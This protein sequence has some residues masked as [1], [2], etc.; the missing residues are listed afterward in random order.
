[1]ARAESK[2]GASSA[3]P[4]DDVGPRRLARECALQML[5]GFDLEAPSD[6]AARERAMQDFW[7]HLDGP[8]VGREYADALVHGVVEHRDALDAAIRAANAT[9]R[10]E[11]MSRVDRTLLRIGAYEML[12]A[13]VP[14]SV[15]IDEAVDM[16]RRFGSDESTAF[17]NGV[18]DR[19]AR[20]HSKL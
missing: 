14:G 1:V 18:L 13:N 15:A 7:T 5:Y 11:R 17:V 4:R 10:L 9:W 16:A 2:P 19:I 6:R 3:A 8:L 20:D 12:H